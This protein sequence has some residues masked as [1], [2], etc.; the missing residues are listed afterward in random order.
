MTKKDEIQQKIIN[1]IVENK[2]R[3]IILASVRS[4]KTRM[5]IKSVDEFTK[6]RFPEILIL[7]PNIDIKVSW[8]REFSILESSL[9][10][11]PNITY[12]T[13]ASIEKM[14]D[15]KF[16]FVLVDEAH[17]LG[18]ENQLPIAG[19]IARD[20]KHCIFAS[21]TYSAETLEAIK[22]HT[23][24]DLIVNYSTEQA[25]KDGIVNNFNVYVHTYHLDNTTKRWFGKIKKW[26]STEAK[27]CARLGRA[28]MNSMGEAKKFAALNRMRFINSCG[29]LGENVNKWIME[30]KHER[31]IL[32]TGDENTGK[33][34][35][36][37]M[38]NSKSKDDSVLKQFQNEEI[39]QLCLINKGGAG[40]TYPNLSTILITA[41][42]SNGEALEQRIGRSLLMDTDEANIHIFVSSEPFQQKWLMSSLASISKERIKY[43]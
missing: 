27:E 4:G 41:I 10:I 3:G 13:F 23:E 24:M 34:Y 29:S 16:D 39:N 1:T 22:S 5:L 26:E 12:C 38:Y 31:F 8:E 19:E 43:L 36:L 25:I 14:K 7:Y 17:L 33:M 18:E 20:N 32:F 11:I 40:I 15:K 9:V 6:K 2:C 30:N 28:I 37:P 42:N 35:N 21:G